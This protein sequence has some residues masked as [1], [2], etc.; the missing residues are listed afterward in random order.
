V[1]QGT[2][3]T[4]PYARFKEV[5]DQ[6]QS[7]RGYQQL[8]ELGYDPDSLGRLASFEVSYMQDPAGTVSQLVDN[9]DLPQDQKDSIKETLSTGRAEGEQSNEPPPAEPSLS[10]EDRQRLE[11]VDQVRQRDEQN[12]RDQRLAHIVSIW[13]RED[14]KDGIDTPEYIKLVHIAATANS[15]QQFET[16]EQLADAARGSVLDYRSQ[17]LGGVVHRTGRGGSPPALPGSPPAAAPPVKFKDMR[18]A[19]RAAEAAI[20]RGELPPMNPGG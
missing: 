7:L 20:E 5:N 6:Y 13:D 15:G 16:L 18:E 3:D 1:G 4:I 12:D 14:K 8:A 11:Y 9:L 19:S 10:P 17:V 2:P